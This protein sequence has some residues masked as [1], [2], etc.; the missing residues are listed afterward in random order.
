MDLLSSNRI[1]LA[2]KSI[3][4]HGDRPSLVD[5]GVDT[6]SDT[7]GDTV[8]ETIAETSH[9]RSQAQWSTAKGHR[10][11]HRPLSFTMKT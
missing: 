1:F 5:T 7:R 3:A 10:S 8:A 6:E 2:R 4:F 11:P 9:K